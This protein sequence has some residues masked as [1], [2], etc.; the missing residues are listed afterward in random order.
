MRFFQA[1]KAI[2]DLDALPGCGISFL[3]KPDFRVEHYKEHNKWDQVTHHYALQVPHTPEV[4]SKELMNSFK[5]NGLYQIPLLCSNKFIEPQ[6][7]CLWRLS[8][9][10]TGDNR[11]EYFSEKLVPDDFEKFRF[12]SLKALHDNNQCAFEDIKK[13]QIHCVMAKVK[14]TSLESSENI[15][16]ILTQLKSI[17]DMEDY[18]KSCIDPLNLT[19]TLSKW[20]SQ[21][22]ILKN[23]H[24]SYAEPIISQ[25]LVMLSDFLIKNGDSNLKEYFTNLALDFAGKYSKIT[26][27]FSYKSDYLNTFYF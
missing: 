21:D 19:F 11:I 14:E 8:Q 25:R 10:D 12:L 1:Y 23:C 22:A 2:G 17:V 3:L 24:F 18:F 7:E 9:W 6:Y 26:S 4:S 27:I 20:N 16:P 5:K 13:I 15:Y